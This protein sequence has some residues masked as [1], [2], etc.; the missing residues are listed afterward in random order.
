LHNQKNQEYH[1]KFH[2]DFH[3]HRSQFLIDHPGYTG[4][5]SDSSFS[6]NMNDESGLLRLYHI[7][8]GLFTGSDGRAHCNSNGPVSPVSEVNYVTPGPGF[9]IE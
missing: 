5:V 1:Q 6:I 4:G 8:G 2:P 7:P 9:S 3:Q